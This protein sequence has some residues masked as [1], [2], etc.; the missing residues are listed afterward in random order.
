MNFASLLDNILD[1]NT[2]PNNPGQPQNNQFDDLIDP[3]LLH[4]DSLG[5]GGGSPTPVS[6]CRWRHDLGDEAEEE[7]E[8]HLLLVAEDALNQHK[9]QGATC[10][11]VRKFAR[12]SL[13]YFNLISLVYTETV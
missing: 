13:F 8:A 1:N 11:I 12:V 6:R 9:V 7:Y 4:G 2:P 10:N 5:Q 3:S